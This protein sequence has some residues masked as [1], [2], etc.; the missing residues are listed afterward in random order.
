MKAFLL[1]VAAFLALGAALGQAACC[2]VG[3][4]G[5]LDRNGRVDGL[6][7]AIL[8][9]CAT[10]A[11]VRQSEP[12]CLLADL[13]DDGDVD[14]SDFG[15]WQLDYTGSCACSG[16]LFEPPR[17]APAEPSDGTSC[18]GPDPEVMDPVYM[19]SGEFHESYTDLRISG[20]GLDFAW[21]RRYRS[22]LG[23]GTAM[24]NGWDFS[25]NVYLG[26]DGTSRVVH[27]GN[28][29]ADTYLSQPDGTWA[30]NEFFRVLAKNPDDTYTLTFADTSHW[31][32]NA[33]DG[34]PAAGKIFSSQDRNGNTLHFS[35]DVPGRLIAVT[36]TLSRVITISY[37]I[38]GFI[39]AVSDFNGRQVQYSYYQDGD[40]GGSYGDLKS[41]RTPVVTG[42]PNNNDFPSGKTTVYTY[43]KGYSDRRLNHNLLTVTDPKGQTFVQNVYASTL[44]PADPDFDHLQRQVWGGAGDIIDAVYVAQT[45]GAGNNFAVIKAIVNDRVGNVR[46]Y[47]YDALNRLVILREYT[48]RAIAS[49]PTT[50]STNR[51]T[52]QLRAGDPSFFET[53]WAFN[54]DSMRTQITDPNGNITNNTYE[55]TLDPGAARRSRGNLRQVQRLPG[56]LGG[57]QVS[58]VESYEYASGFGGCGCG[59]NF[60]TRHVDG[61]GNETLH[62][63]D[64]SGNRTH[65]QHRIISTV[66]DW[67]YNS[68]GQVLTHTLPA[69]G[70]GHRRVD[71]YTY[72]SVGPQ[73]GYP[74]TSVIDSGGAALTTTFEYDAVG[75]VVRKID[76]NGAD[77][78]YTYNALDQVVHELSREVVAAGGNRYEKLYWYD[79]N[80][81][82]IR[83]DTQ[84]KDETGAVA[85]NTHFS[86]IYEYEI[87]NRLTQTCQE[88]GSALL[89][90]TD[91]TCASFA[92]GDAVATRYQY[93]ANRN[94]TLTRYG[95]ATNGADPFNTL[96]MAYDERD[97]LFQSI[98][99]EG[100]GASSTD[101]TDYDGNGNMTSG[102]QGLESSPRVTSYTYDGYDRRVTTTDATGNVET[103]HYDANGNV[104]SQ[105][106]DGE[107]SD[108]AG[109]AGNLRLSDQ[110]YQYDAMDRRVRQDIA[111]FDTQPT[112]PNIGDGFSTTQWVYADNSQVTS[113]ATD[114]PGHV[115]AYTYDTVNR[116]SRITDAKNN[117]M[118]YTYDADSNIAQTVQTDKSDLGNP[119]QTFTTTYSYDQLDRLTQIV[120]N[121]GNTHQH[122]YD[123]RGNRVLHTDARNNKVRYEY[124]GLNRMIRASRDMNANSIFTDAADIVTQQSWD[125]SS[126]VTSQIDDNGN[127]TMYLYDSL[128]RLRHDH[129]RRL[130]E[131]RGQLRRSRQRD[132]LDGCQRDHCQLHL[133]F[134]EP[135]HRQEHRSGAGGLFGYYLRELRL[136]WDEPAHHARWT[137]T[138]R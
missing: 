31:D 38:H 104:T 73:T 131:R 114:L 90:N 45:P 76:P 113:V 61:R 89:A 136:R 123:S 37:D 106:K 78:L 85:A 71:A 67:T 3:G 86:T 57:D 112:Q 66:E 87:L 40:A 94:R 39:S 33:L 101:Q 36:D 120:D 88:R 44:N 81:N 134:V 115:T 126:R 84:N 58:I 25:Y 15:A 17:K 63:Y 96:T 65:T 13:D 22:R 77:T 95:Q 59:A 111:H 55:L 92:P 28:T 97:L 32:F 109:G 105:R 9:G 1:T 10:R 122:A 4:L 43:S 8:T 72:Y 108:V 99:A 30:R 102:Q 116:V 74:Q 135:R 124:D 35:Y 42:T 62:T 5:D 110:T 83:N 46:E 53:R 6:D 19:F 130:H 7:F 56:A 117:Y 107:L 52:G 133:R 21:A 26:A 12:T 24:G 29:R 60:V 11:G 129:L 100:S 48:G 34:S 68:F 121:L 18:G 82:L 118:D 16:N 127:M 79:A 50:E 98:R 20:R 41:V 14:M 93:D 49:V 138:R 128:N 103:M 125:E 132:Q 2:S 75:N 91:L 23:P 64:A 80:D 69:N 70:S 27:D 54:V 137:M 51:P 47:L 119:S